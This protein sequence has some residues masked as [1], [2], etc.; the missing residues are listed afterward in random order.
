MST[1]DGNVT[2]G[3]ELWD[4]F[5]NHF[6]SI[7]KQL[8]KAPPSL[9]GDKDSSIMWSYERIEE[10]LN[11]NARSGKRMRG[12]ATV[13]SYLHVMG[14]DNVKEEDLKIA[15]SLGWAIEIMQASFLVA[16][17]IMD[18]SQ[19]RRG[20]P[21]WYKNDGVGLQ[22]VNDSM[23]L[24]SCVFLLL[25]YHC[26]HKPYYADLVDLFREVMTFTELGQSL[27]MET[28]EKPEVDF[29]YFTKERYY[30]II[31][32]KT[33]FYSFYLPIACALYLTGNADET[34]LKKSCSIL[35]EMGCYFQVQDDFIDC[36]GNP[37]ITGKIG[38]DIESNKCCWLI[39]K[40]LEL[41]SSEQRQVLQKNYGKWD[42]EKKRAVV[43][44]YEQLNLESHYHKY[45]EETY[46]KLSTDIK[47]FNH[48]NIPRVVFLELLDKIYKRKK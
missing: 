42:K 17:D 41:C 8:I 45:E 9:N 12:L 28:S 44:V 11:Y 16:D 20:K 25:K 4:L 6:P 10:L 29:T 26:R 19:T 5:E 14:K 1:S 34:T 3:I 27:D 46:A 38:T 39:V 15:L 24:E 18:Q 47:E 21:C 13:S 48:P 35:T 40:A 33:S 23:V 31:K 36:Y 7:V 32:Y 2:S 22:A 37:D 43:D 30:A